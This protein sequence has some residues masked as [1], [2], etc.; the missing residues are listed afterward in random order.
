MKFIKNILILSVC[1]VFIG[2]AKEEKVNNTETK[3][4]Q[5]RVVFFP[6]I[7][8]KGEY[9]IVVQQGAT[10]TDAGATGTLNGQPNPVTTTGTVNTAVPGIYT[11]TYETK[12][13]DGF[14]ASD[15]R[16]VAVIGNDVLNATDFS[17]T[18]ARYIGSAAN[19]QTSTWT[20]TAKG[21]YTVINPG[22]AT[23]VT[24]TAV[25]YTGNRI[26]IPPQPTSAGKFS[27]AISSVS[28]IYYPTASPAYYQWAIVNAG[29]GTALRTFKKL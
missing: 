1:Y 11:L 4:G 28:G 10:Y 23:G 8:T 19:G 24:A 16:S 18:Y 6:E 21:V 26:V 22:G 20:K 27:S 5:S 29:Y 9:V 13:S 3:V 14:S 15:Y 7:E 12:N 17:G 25:N 2:C